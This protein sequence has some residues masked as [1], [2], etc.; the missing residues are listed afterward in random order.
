ML[1]FFFLMIRR[2][3]R[4]TQSRSSAASDVYKRQLQDVLEEGVVGAALRWRA[5]EV[6]APGVAL[7]GLAVPLLD[8][9]GRI[10]EHHVEGAQTVA[11]DEGGVAQRVAGDDLEVLDAVQH[12]VHPG[13]GRGYVDE[14]LPVEAERARVAA[15]AFHLGEG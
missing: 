15:P 7:P 13:D 14:F 12:Q 6:A 2:P 11:L 4:S 10:G 3:P 8:G 9:V 5:E 1:F